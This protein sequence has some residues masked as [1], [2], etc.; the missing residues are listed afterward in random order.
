MHEAVR[1]SRRHMDLGHGGP[2]GCVVVK[3]G[4]I[5]GRGWNSVLIQNDPTAHAEVM[6]IR[7]ACTR[8]QTYQLTGCDIFTSCEPCPMCMGAI[9]WSRPDRVFYANTRQD[10]ADCGFDDSFIYEE[11]KL[12]VSDRT[13]PMMEMDKREAIQVFREWME[14]PDR[15]QY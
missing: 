4:Q 1:L 8:L 2:F 12:P 3:E 11:L 10:A 5:V 14:K 9:Y 13:I 7:D 6:A 15:E